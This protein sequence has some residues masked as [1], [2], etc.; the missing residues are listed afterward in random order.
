MMS[1]KIIS[2]HLESCDNNCP[3][4]NVC[5]HI[6]KNHNLCL[7]TNFIREEAIKTNYKVYESICKTVTYETVCRLVAYDNYNIT[8]F[9]ENF[10][11]LLDLVSKIKDISDQ[12]QVTVY[13]LDQILE[14]PE[15][16]KL[17]L[18]KDDET[19]T[20]FKSFIDNQDIFFL[21]FLFT[22]EYIKDKYQ[23]VLSLWSDRK[24]FNSDITLDSCLYSWIINSECPYSFRN[25]IDISHDYSVRNCPYNK[26]KIKTITKEDKINTLFNLESQCNKDNCIYC[27]LLSKD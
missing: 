24:N 19:Y 3:N 11:I 5:Y 22:Q 9:Y 27:R 13:N 7:D 4:R 23:E 26:N 21:H 25:Y 18:I 6:H 8:T 12:V 17:Y 15:Y 20:N 1:S 2:L 16:Q 14:F 10:I